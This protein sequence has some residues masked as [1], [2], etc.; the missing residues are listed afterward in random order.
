MAVIMPAA[1]QLLKDCNDMSWCTCSSS[2]SRKDLGDQLQ[3][4]CGEEWQ[5]HE[6]N[7]EPDASVNNVVLSNDNRDVM[8]HPVYSSGTAAVRGQEVLKQN[9]HYYWEIKMLTNLYGT[10]IMVG[11]GTSKVVPAEWK[12]RFCSMLGFDGESWGYS[13]MGKIQHGKLSCNYGSRFSVG[14]LIGVHLDM[15]AGTLE[16]YLNRKPL[17]VAFRGLKNHELY[18][19][20]S[21]TAAQSAMRITCALS[22]VPTLQMECL[23]LITNNVSLLKQYWSIPG[24]ARMVGKRYFW[25]VPRPPPEK[26]RLELED[27]VVLPVNYSD[28]NF[29]RRKR[30]CT[31]LFPPRDPRK[32]SL[33]DRITLHEVFSV[34][35]PQIHV[36]LSIIGPKEEAKQASDA[37]Q[38]S[39]SDQ[40]ILVVKDSSSDVYS[41]RINPVSEDGNESSDVE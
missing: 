12:L 40:Q 8:F 20:V 37:G 9:V 2:V 34:K 29:I 14:S 1:M 38:A 18:P 4:S 17:G 27:E 5:V 26:T 28:H 11:V 19:M 39:C 32:H 41:S 24:L 6:W 21:S 33:H 35:E 13:Y 25:L 10:D 15:C 22:E 16:Y 7:W 30:F 36:S 23:K 31:G 3:C